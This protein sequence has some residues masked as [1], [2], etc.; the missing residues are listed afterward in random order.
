M[1]SIDIIVRTCIIS[2]ISSKH[3]IQ[4]PLTKTQETC[5]DQVCATKLAK[6][7]PCTDNLKVSFGKVASL[8]ETRSFSLHYAYDIPRILQRFLS[9]AK[10]RKCFIEEVNP[11][12]LLM[13]S[14]R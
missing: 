4:K 6:N 2:V 9:K 1:S 10:D 8:V 7:A 11:T 13:I 12:E 14:L 5:D 3:L